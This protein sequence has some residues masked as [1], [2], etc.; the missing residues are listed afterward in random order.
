VL[1]TPKQPPAKIALSYPSVV[2]ADVEDELSFS[3]LKG[4][5]SGVLKN[6]M[7][8][9]LRKRSGCRVEEIEHKEGVPVSS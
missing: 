8:E 9:E 7:M 2:N 6:R 4:E 5:T 1:Y 3:W